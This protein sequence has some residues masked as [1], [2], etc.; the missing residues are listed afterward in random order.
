MNTVITNTESRSVIKVGGELV[1]VGNMTGRWQELVAYYIAQ[2]QGKSSTRHSY[3]KALNQFFSWADTT[4]RNWTRLSKIDILAYIDTL[5]S[6]DKQRSAFTVNLYIV[7]I[8]GF[9]KWIDHLT[10]EPHIPNIAEDIKVKHKRNKF[11]KKALSA[12]QAIELLDYFKNNIALARCAKHDT[13]GKTSVALRDFAIANLMIRTGL[14]TIEV[15]RANIKHITQVQ[16]R[17]HNEPALMIMGKGHDDFD[18][19]VILSKDTYDPIKAYLATRPGALAGEPLFECEGRASKGRRLST[20]R[21]QSVIKQGLRAIGLTDYMDQLY[22]AHSL[23]HTA[24]TL[25][26]EAGGSVFDVQKMLR[27]SSPATSEIYVKEKME[28]QR[29]DNAPEHLLDDILSIPKLDLDI[30]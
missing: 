21:I 13:E 5:Q 1:S 14:R 6:P 8:R 18:D 22:S 10:I 4:G 3:T 12:S 26:L 17:T 23:R 20:R 30:C 27:H 16:G 15:S 19:F 2:K 9:Y 11:Q 25:I 7:A 24:G 29:I 28:Q